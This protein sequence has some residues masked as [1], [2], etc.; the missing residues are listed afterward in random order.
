[1]YKCGHVSGCAATLLTK[2]PG[3]SSG[4]CYFPRMEL[5]LYRQ[6]VG[7]SKEI[8]DNNVKKEEFM[9]EWRERYLSVN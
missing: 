8:S 6:T 2:F 9:R 5:K 3:Q 1:M 7:R 4:N